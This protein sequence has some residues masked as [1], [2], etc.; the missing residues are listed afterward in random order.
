M[1]ARI[2]FAVVCVACCLAGAAVSQ[3]GQRHPEAQPRVISISVMK[4]TEGGFTLF[5]LK[6]DG[7]VDHREVSTV[8]GKGFS[9]SDK[10]QTLTE[11]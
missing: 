8:P 3:E 9:T 10:W 5:R 7:S 6:S 4:L 11:K 2:M 1:K